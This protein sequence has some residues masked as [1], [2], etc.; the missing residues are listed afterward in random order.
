MLPH[1]ILTTLFM[2]MLGFFIHSSPLHAEGFYYGL[3]LGRATSNT[4]GISAATFQNFASTQLGLTVQ[5]VEV[6]QEK[7]QT[8]NRTMYVGY[9]RY[10]Y[11]LEVGF[12]DL[13]NTLTSAQLTINDPLTGNIRFGM[14]GYSDTEGYYTAING[15]LPIHRSLRISGKLGIHFWEQRQ[16]LF[17]NSQNLPGPALQWQLNKDEDISAFYGLGLKWHAIGIEYTRHAI[18]STD[19]D[20]LTV[21]FEYRL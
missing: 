2:A 15:K 9:S 10:Y 21:S 8:E 4:T 16:R 6:K 1:A 7:T 20:V 18:K 13:G 5:L 11:D 19:F 14:G 12:L 17:L 3:K